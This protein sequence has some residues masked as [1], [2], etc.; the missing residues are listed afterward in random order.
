MRF[1][2][3]RLPTHTDLITFLSAYLPEQ[4]GI[5][6]VP[7]LYHTPRHPLYDPSHTPVSRIILSITPTAGVYSAFN[8]SGARYAPVCFLHRPWNLDRRSIRHGGLVVASHRSFDAH[9]TVGWNTALARQL[10]VDVE[11]AI[12]LQGYKGDPQRKIGLVAAFE[13]ADSLSLL[14]NK[15]RAAFSGTGEL[16]VNPSLVNGPNSN[17]EI[18]VLAIMNAFHAEE[19]TRVL[20]AA[21]QQGWI[22]NP[23]QGHQILYLTGAARPHG[24]E[25]VAKVN[26]PTLCVGHRACEE[27]G[28][29]YL[30]H[31]LKS[32][33]SDVEVMEI[34]E[35][36]EDN[37]P[38][39]QTKSNNE[40]AI[41]L[42]TEPVKD[43][44]MGI[45]NS[46]GVIDTRWH[47]SVQHPL[48]DHA[49]RCSK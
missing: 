15:I 9:L 5:S 28:I 16:F 11:K 8:Q 3:P 37:Q 19:V 17:G 40:Q 35:E 32:K 26:M 43:D 21:H 24:L 23:D 18:S 10:G 20:L 44:T 14:S 41:T 42:D 46:T 1:P 47:T 36:E 48:F 27:W 38:Q 2:E 13:K 31:E 6:D 12:C 39:S 25:A 22:T 4:S 7:F 29:K 33:W 49:S 45:E 30:A 34:L